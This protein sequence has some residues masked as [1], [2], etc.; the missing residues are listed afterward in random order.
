LYNAIIFHITPDSHKTILL[1]GLPRSGTTLVCK[2]L[3]SLP[4]IVALNEPMNVM[5]FQGRPAAQVFMMIDQ[6]V[7]ENR[8]SVLESGT[9]IS[10]QTKGM[11]P[12]NSFPSEFNNGLRKSILDIGKIRIGKIPDENFSIAVKH[13]AAFAAL[14]DALSS[15]YPCFAIVRNPLA[16]LVSWTTVDIP[17]HHGR[18]PVGEALD[19]ALKRA[20]EQLPD[21][22]DRQWHATD[23]FFRKYVESLP[24]ERIIK[25]EELISTHGRCLEKITPSARL[26]NENLADQ[27]RYQEIDPEM[28]RMYGRKLLSKG[29]HYENLYKKEEITAEIEKALMLH[30]FNR[31]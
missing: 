5:E 1:T 22:T 27:A 6:F 29:G 14:L 28:I 3:N 13:N 4:D 26:L 18:T 19:P 9:A 24:R 25:Y 2:L 31:Q 15:R 30:H 17:V 8:K 21:A 23:W 16:A 7:E 10:K 12:D 20:L 11:I